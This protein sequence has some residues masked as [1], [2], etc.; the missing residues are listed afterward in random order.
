MK[1]RIASLLAIILILS[2]AMP[3]NV[4]GDSLVYPILK[5]GVQYYQTTF[6]SGLKYSPNWYGTFSYAPKASEILL[7]DDSYSKDLGLCLFS[8]PIGIQPKGEQ[9]GTTLKAIT[10][11]QADNIVKS[12]S[13]QSSV[14]PFDNEILEVIQPETCFSGVWAGAKLQQKWACSAAVR[15]LNNNPELTVRQKQYLADVSSQNITSVDL[16]KYDPN[17]YW[18]L[19]GVTANWSDSAHWSTSSGGLG[20]ASVPTSDDNVYFDAASFTST[21]HTVVQ[22]AECYC[23]NMDWTGAT[24]SPTF[25]LDS[26]YSYYPEVSGSTTFIAAMSITTPD[27]G[28]LFLPPNGTTKTL[29]TNGLT[30]APTI[31]LFGAGGTLQLSDNFAAPSIGITKGTLDTNSKNVTLTQYLYVN[32]GNGSDCSYSL[33]SSVITINHATSSARTAVSINAGAHLVS[34]NIGTSKF[35]ISNTSTGDVWIGNETAANTNLNLYDVTV[36]GSGNF[37]TVFYKYSIGNTWTLHNLTVDRSA[38]AKSI[39]AS[40]SAS[41]TVTDLPCAVSGTTV[42][43]FA[44]TLGTNAWTL[45]KAGGGTVAL[46]YLNLSY[47]TGSPATTWYYGSHS[48]IGSGV[49]GWVTGA[50]ITITNTPTTK[51]FGTVMP[52]TTYYAKGF[53][54]S[55]PVASN[56]TSFAVSNNGTASVNLAM[57]CTNATGGNT[58]TLVA[59]S[60]TGD[61]FEVMVYAEGDNPASGLVLT[62][63]PQAWKSALAAAGTINWDFKEIL[64]GTGTGKAGTFSDAVQKTYTITITGS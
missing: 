28:I 11:E 4:S 62:T 23:K 43:T 52:G 10:K 42:L 2:M 5:D 6:P 61:Q 26:S 9:G 12:Y 57:S 41:V 64:G 36:Q 51:D 7:F 18:V 53:A 45:A 63:S 59:S 50:P 35:V 30:T 21:D 31:V 19:G 47:N 37:A 55:N 49:T 33:G 58:W 20:G 15:Y 27:N 22:N 8:M 34:P 40:A 17:R 32:Y 38:A 16:S 14:E 48:T 25:A 24:N 39:K 54:P 29:T 44:T 60:P 46:D 1:V 56:E 3:V 13:L